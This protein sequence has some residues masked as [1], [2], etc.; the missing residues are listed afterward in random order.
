MKLGVSRI[1]YESLDIK[2]VNVKQWR[3]MH[4][5]AWCHEYWALINKIE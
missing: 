3:L 1:Y 4:Y 5:A 2:I